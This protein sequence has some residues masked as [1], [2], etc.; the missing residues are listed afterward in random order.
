MLFLSKQKPP[1]VSKICS[2]EEI[3]VM[4]LIVRVARRSGLYY[5]LAFTIYGG[6]IISC[7]FKNGRLIV[8]KNWWRCG[9]SWGK[10]VLKLV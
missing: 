4:V 5:T 2:L 8:L 7:K 10:S 9:T 3:G 6:R 1:P